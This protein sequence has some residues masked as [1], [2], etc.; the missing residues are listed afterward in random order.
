MNQKCGMA[1]FRIV[2]LF[3]IIVAIATQYAIHNSVHDP[4]LKEI[5]SLVANTME[6]AP[7]CPFESSCACMRFSEELVRNR[8][9]SIMFLHIHKNAGTT[10][11]AM[12]KANKV[13]YPIR[14]SGSN[15]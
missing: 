3:C 8:K 9:S 1:A 2:S 12:A 7:D 5:V 4:H 13:R 14:K 15:S 11:C 10:M 6:Y